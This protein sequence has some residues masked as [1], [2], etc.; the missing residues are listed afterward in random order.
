MSQISFLGLRVCPCSH[1]SL[2]KDSQQR[3]RELHILFQL[4]QSARRPIAKHSYEHKDFAS[5]LRTLTTFNSRQGWLNSQLS[6]QLSSPFQN[7]LRR[8]QLHYVSRKRQQSRS[9]CSLSKRRQVQGFS[10]S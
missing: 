5:R 4:L 7:Q 1:Y 9:P 2:K 10:D 3:A 6:S 8:S